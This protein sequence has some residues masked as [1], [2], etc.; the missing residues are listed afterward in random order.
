M[1]K[2]PP[3]ATTLLLA[4]ALLLTACQSN[5]AVRPTTSPPLTVSAAAD[6]VYAF[7]DLGRAFEQ[8]TGI[9]VVFNFGST[10]QL[11]EQIEQGAPADLF[12]AANVSYVED[13]ASKGRLL[14]DTVTLYGRGRITLWA[15]ADNPLHNVSTM[16]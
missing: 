16:R 2:R 13:L 4:L 11:A 14:P 15:R 6:L 5:V 8:E 12:A 7:T 3:R 10:G 9:R 1:S